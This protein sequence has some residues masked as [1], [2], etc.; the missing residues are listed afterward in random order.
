[1]PPALPKSILLP[2]YQF[3]IAV[4]LLIDTTN[5]TNITIPEGK[6]II[7]KDHLVRIRIVDKYDSSVDLEES[8]DLYAYFEFSPMYHIVLLPQ[9]FRFVIF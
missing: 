5:E 3:G 2:K 6:T 9:E 8:G 7:N 1:M 4:F